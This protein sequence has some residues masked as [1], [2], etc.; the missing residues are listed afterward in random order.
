MDWSLFQPQAR[1]PLLRKELV[2]PTPVRPDRLDFLLR[3]IFCSHSF[4]ISRSYVDFLVVQ[5]I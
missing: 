1:Y 2:Y 3:L 4:T 5:S